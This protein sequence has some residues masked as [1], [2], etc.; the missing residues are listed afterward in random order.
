M[1]TNLKNSEKNTIYKKD[2]FVIVKYENEY[3][4]GKILNVTESQVRVNV[5][6][7]SGVIGWK[8]PQTP[9]VLWYEKNDVIK[10]ITEPQKLN[11]RGIYTVAE[12]KDYDTFVN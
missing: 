4:P 11:N 3:Y 10:I 7:K 8:W 1:K 2:Y 5:M 6:V 9:D 12:M